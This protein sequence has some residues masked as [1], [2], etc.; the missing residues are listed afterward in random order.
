MRLVHLSDVHLGYRQYQRLT[1]GGANQRE[2]DVATTF[3]R[4]ID[5]V[6]ELRPDIVL[7]AGD[8]F[9]S[10]RPTNP[11]ILHAFTQLARLRS[12]IP[13]AIV[14]IVAG[15]HDTP[16]TSETGCILRLFVPL[17]IHVAEADAKRFDFPERS[18][19]VLAVPD[20][21]GSHPSL[22]PDPGAKFNILVMHGE[23]E[24]V[25]PAGYVG[26]RA[27]MEISRQEI[28]AE[29]WSYVALGHYHVHRQVAPNAYYS[30]SLDYTSANVWGEL[31]EER[32]GRLPGKGLVEYDLDAAKLTFHHLSPSRDLVDLPA[33][34]ARG[35]SAAEVDVAI[36][37]R[38]ERAGDIDHRIV[39]LIIRD[40]P[41]HIVRGLDH[42]AL[43]DYKRRALY[44]HL[45]TRRPEVIRE[46]GHAAPG[47]RP[48]LSDIVRSK[49]MSRSIESD[50]DRD[51]LV[52]LGL[53]YLRE[54]EVLATASAAPASE[55]SES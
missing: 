51:E 38:V 40:I 37:E 28:G 31:M 11:A 22:D 9:H 19:S 23:V 21:F 55:M 48:S 27:P 20:M 4:A 3:R 17:G 46:H 15:N 35:M 43:R 2:A 24:G 16:R 42:K 33:L 13:E 45:D 1:P 26:D 25:L 10:V 30:G 5:K 41:R 49:L 53:Q 7:I 50:L 14:V 29:R 34:S 6:V 8:V 47:K 36:R 54:A 39:R 12:S 52:E 18:L 32:I 44:F